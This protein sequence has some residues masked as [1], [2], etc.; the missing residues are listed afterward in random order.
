[1]K[2]GGDKV[3]GCVLASDAFFPFR[4]SIDA[5]AKAGITAIIEPGGSIRDNE[6]I[7]ASDEHELVLIFTGFR[8]FKH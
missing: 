2:K 5:A 3:K 8:C 6:V 7:Q 4:D 1:I